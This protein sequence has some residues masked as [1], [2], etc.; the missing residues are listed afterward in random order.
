[1][2]ELLNDQVG[3]CLQLSDWVVHRNDYKRK[4]VI[5]EDL[6]KRVTHHEE[7]CK[8]IDGTLETKLDIKEIDTIK[9]MVKQLPDIDEVE[10]TKNFVKSNI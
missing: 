3:D 7:R 5:I 2:K 10:K 1:M 6:Q 4:C 8:T 9:T